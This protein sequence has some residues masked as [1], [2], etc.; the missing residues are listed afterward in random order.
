M[1][2]NSRKGPISVEANCFGPRSVLFTALVTYLLFSSDID[3]CATNNG[4]CEYKCQNEPGSYNCSC[5]EGSELQE[6]GLNCG[7]SEPGKVVIHYILYR[8]IT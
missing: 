5:P 6:N 1:T 3:E 8:N 4:S 2:P 7:P